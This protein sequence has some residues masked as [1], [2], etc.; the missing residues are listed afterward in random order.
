MS[1][2][3][4]LDQKVKRYILD[5]IDSDCYREEPATTTAEKIAFLHEIFMAEYGWAVERYGRSRALKE[6]LQGLPSAVHIAFY[7]GDILDLAKEWGSLPEDASE[8]KE[9]AILENYWRL[10]AA[11]IGQL[12]DGYRV[13]GLTDRLRG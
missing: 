12:F 1:K 5:N 2:A 6:W 10:L 11:K 9:Q 13:P 8:A 4:E 3:S 7:N